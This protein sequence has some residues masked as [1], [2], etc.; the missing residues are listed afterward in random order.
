MELED[1]VLCVVLAEM[2]A[3]FD[4]EALK[5]QAI[6]ARSFAYMHLMNNK[7]SEYGAHVDDSTTYQVY[8]ISF[9]N[10]RYI[11]NIII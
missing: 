4:V 2:P 7:Y 9:L 8:N 3:D 11:H 5:A 1:Y 10:M 6:C